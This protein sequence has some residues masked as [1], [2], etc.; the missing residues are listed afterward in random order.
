[1]VGS[2]AGAKSNH[3]GRMGLVGDCQSYLHYVQS[4]FV[5]LITVNGWPW[6]CCIGCYAR[7]Q[8]RAVACQ[9]LCVLPRPNCTGGHGGCMCGTERQEKVCRASGD[10]EEISPRAP[11]WLLF[12]RRRHAP[13]NFCPSVNLCL[14]GLLSAA[15]EQQAF[16]YWVSH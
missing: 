9:Y 16:F 13:D 6:C 3:G 8:R 2:F 4:P 15:V 1:M 11:N 14:Y 7:Y 5:V 12:K 10:W